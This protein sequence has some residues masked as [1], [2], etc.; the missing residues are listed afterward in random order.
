MTATGKLS[1]K[2]GWELEAEFEA[3]DVWAGIPGG[4]Y[5]LRNIRQDGFHVAREVR[6]ERVTLCSGGA[7]PK[8]ESF[9]LGS[10]RVKLVT[11]PHDE[12]P[13]GSDPRGFYAPKW[14]LRANYLVEDVFGIKGLSVR[15]WQRYFF[16]AY[17][18]TPSH[19]P[20]GLVPAARFYPILDFAVIYPTEQILPE[21]VIA[22]IRV[23]FRIESA[24]D[25]FVKEKASALAMVMAKGEFIDWKKTKNIGDNQ[26]G[27]FRDASPSPSLTVKGIFAAAEKPLLWEVLAQ[28]IRAGQASDWDNIHQWAVMPGGALP[29]TPGMALG[30][31]NHWRWFPQ[32]V[33]GKGLASILR[34][35]GPQYG[36]IAGPG[37]PM[38]E[39]NLP[40]QDLRLAI[41][42]RDLVPGVVAAYPNGIHAFDELFTKHP[43][44]PKGPAPIENGADLAS[45][46]SFLVRRDRSGDAS[47][48]PKPF[49]GPLFVNGLFFAHELR[50]FISF[51]IKIPNDER[52]RQYIPLR[53]RKAAWV[54]P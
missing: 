47:W 11:P 5:V 10:A 39:P 35:T 9:T 19:E 54:R 37:T 34:G 44:R 12:G 26:A 14:A 15:F 23:D 27:L 50:D 22:E 28:G 41:T 16:T 17:G 36:G 21:N 3:A 6:V 7:K 53:P 31:H 2:S 45:W 13:Q 8:E 42:K 20:S 48:P 40:D 51:G 43:D 52:A 46:F 25:E 38:I 4:G 24:M 29:P 30:L 49:G 18:A 32:A 33:T 1:H